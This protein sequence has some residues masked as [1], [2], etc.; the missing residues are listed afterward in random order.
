MLF[1]IIC[2]KILHLLCCRFQ[3]AATAAWPPVSAYPAKRTSKRWLVEF[4]KAFIVHFPASALAD[5]QRFS[6]LQDRHQLV[7][8]GA[9]VVEGADHRVQIWLLR[10]CCSEPPLSRTEISVCGTT[11]ALPPNGVSGWLMMLFC[12]TSTVSE[13]GA[14]ARRRRARR[15]GSSPP[16]RCV[17]SQSPSRP[18]RSPAAERPECRPENV[19]GTDCPGAN[20]RTVRASSGNAPAAVALVN[21]VLILLRQR[22]IGL[23]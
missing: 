12:I 8:R 11:T 1:I 15:A 21:G 6:S 16:S 23:V 7:W 5:S 4:I 20:R 18:A 22:E 10:T 17:S 19:R 14:T 13:P 9:Q 3:R 2:T